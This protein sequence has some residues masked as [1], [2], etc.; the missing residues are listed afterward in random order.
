MYTSFR[1]QN[2]RCF[3][4]LQMND[5][6]RINLIA[7]KN[8]TGKTSLLEAILLHSGHISENVLIRLSPGNRKLINAVNKTSEYPPLPNWNTLFRNLDTKAV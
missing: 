7:G 5:L 4:D 8:N 2:F 1:V 6:A 3:A